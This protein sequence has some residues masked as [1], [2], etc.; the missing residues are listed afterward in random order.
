MRTHQLLNIAL[1]AILV[2]AIA[3]AAL[4]GWN[5]EVD[6]TAYERMR[7]AEM[8]RDSIARRAAEWRIAAE[9]ALAMAD[10]VRARRDSVEAAQPPME[11]VRAGVIRTMKHAKMR[12]A[13]DTLSAE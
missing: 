12:A 8:E 7:R 1:T 5:A 13:L 4:R 2:V 10:S 6:A 9:W 11:D 3:Y